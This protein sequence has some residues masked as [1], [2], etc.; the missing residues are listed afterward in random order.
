MY[1]EAVT[2]RMFSSVN[3]RLLR[4]SIRSRQVDAIEAFLAVPD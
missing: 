3:P 1:M 2:M 4:S